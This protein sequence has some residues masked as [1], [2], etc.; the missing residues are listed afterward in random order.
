MK[1]LDPRGPLV[2]D[3]RELG[4]RPGA[5]QRTS[6]TVP[7]PADLGSE[8]IGVPEGSDLRLDLLL[9]AVMEGVLV[10]GT[11]TGTAHGQCVRCLEDVQTPLEVRLQELYAYPTASTATD[12][13]VLAMQGDLID[14]EP[15]VRDAVVPTLPFQPVCREDCP[16]L[17]TQYGLSDEA[18]E[19]GA[20][21]LPADVDP[22]WAALAQ[23]A[24]TP[25]PA[26]AGDPTTPQTEQQNNR[27]G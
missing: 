6:R 24:T 27:K 20:P 12:E 17:P 13:D 11:V 1:H 4:R 14:L 15:A 7:A 16:G 8:V 23:L 26:R 10:T 3:T 22:R 25:A 18:F 21:E 19:E 9:E 5:S 2:V